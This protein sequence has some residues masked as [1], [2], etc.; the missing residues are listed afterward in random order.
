MPEKTILDINNVKVILNSSEILFFD[1]VAIQGNQ[2]NIILGK[3]GKGKTSLIKTIMGIFPYQCGCISYKDKELD[4]DGYRTRDFLQEVQYVMQD[5][6]SCFHPKF[7][8]SQ[9]LQE[10]LIINN[11]NY[12]TATLLEALQT[13]NLDKS[14]LKKYR[15]ELSGGQRQRIALARALLLKPNIIIMDEPTSALDKMLVKDLIDLIKS[16]SA[17][18]IIVTHD[19]KFAE[20]VADNLICL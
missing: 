10:G 8:V 13:V 17:T 1:K 5:L 6:Y 7:D 14:F 9:I 12:S 11:I 4:K 18:F 16:I 20:R 3:S 19:L 2:K 15:H